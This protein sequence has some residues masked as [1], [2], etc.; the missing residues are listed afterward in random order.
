MCPGCKH[1]ICPRQC[2][3]AD[4]EHPLPCSAFA[5]NE[6]ARAARHDDYALLHR[7][8]RE[9]ASLPH[10]S[11]GTTPWTLSLDWTNLGGGW[12]FTVEFTDSLN[13][14]NWQPVSPVSQWPSAG[15]HFVINID[16]LLKQGFFRV[17]ATP[18]IL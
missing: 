15:T 3:S 2:I 16:P 11:P 13:N 18:P 17:T 10:L 5:P 7:G 9:C 12:R 8:K 4:T 14:P 1:W 6:G